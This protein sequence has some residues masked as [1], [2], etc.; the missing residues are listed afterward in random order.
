MTLRSDA[1]VRCIS[2][3][4]VTSN[5]NEVIPPLLSRSASSVPNLSARRATLYPEL[6]G[7]VA[8]CTVFADGSCSA[9]PLVTGAALPRGAA[10]VVS[11]ASTRKF[12]KTGRCDA[13]NCRRRPAALGASRS[14]A[15]AFRLCLRVVRSRRYRL[16]PSGES[17]DSGHST[18]S[19]LP[20][21][22]RLLPSVVGL[23]RSRVLAEAFSAPRQACCDRAIRRSLACPSVLVPASARVGTRALGASCSRIRCARQNLSIVVIALM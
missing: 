16:C 4:P 12:G 7:S 5:S 21:S 8:W 2:A 3:G 6:D 11:G 22:R 10:A 13:R 14:L 17:G 20:F 18:R 9:P 23:A 1:G 15:G 19:L